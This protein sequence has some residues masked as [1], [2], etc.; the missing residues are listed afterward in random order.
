MQLARLDPPDQS[1]PLVLQVPPDLRVYKATRVLLALQGPL[2]LQVLKG[3]RVTPAQRVQREPQDSMVEL[4]PPAPPDH[5]GQ[6]VQLVQQDPKDFKGI[7][8]SPV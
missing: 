7:P 5:S 6:R 1:D 4:A 8:V 2:A 3:S